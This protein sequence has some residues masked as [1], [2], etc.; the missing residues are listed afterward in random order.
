[1]T[2]AAGSGGSGVVHECA[3][4]MGRPKGPTSGCPVHSAARA[5]RTSL[6]GRGCPTHSAHAA[7]SSLDGGA[8][9]RPAEEAVGAHQRKREE[10]LARQLTRELGGGRAS[11]RPSLA[12]GSSAGAPGPVGEEE[13]D[14]EEASP[15]ASDSESERAQMK[16]SLYE[17]LGGGPTAAVQVFYHKLREDHKLQEFFDGLDMDVQRR[18]QLLFM[19]FIFGGPDEYGGHTCAGTCGAWSES[20]YKSH[21]RLVAKGLNESHFDRV[22]YHLRN[23]LLALSVPQALIEEAMAVVETTRRAIFPLDRPPPTSETAAAAAART[24]GLCPF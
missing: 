11:S 19:S 12:G 7:R 24:R 9:P 20:L 16:L 1:M 2:L 8:P 14:E 15:C 13:E 3:G 21:A 18:K 17:R 23:S 6:D 22:L 4:S 10:L 5:V